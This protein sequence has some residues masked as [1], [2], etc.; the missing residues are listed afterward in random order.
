MLPQG[1]W[2]IDGLPEANRNRMP[3]T[4]I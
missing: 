3:Y 1:A 4:I 2:R